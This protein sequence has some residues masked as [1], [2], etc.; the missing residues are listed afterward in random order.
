[1]IKVKTKE[2]RLARVSPNGMFIPSDH[3]IEVQAT[4]YIMRLLNV[5]EDIELEPKKTK[6]ETKKKD[7]VDP[8]EGDQ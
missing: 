3:F 2:G 4:P 8:S 6:T 7:R 5:H 1:M